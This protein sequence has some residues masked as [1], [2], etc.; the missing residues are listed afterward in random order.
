[1][2]IAHVKRKSVNVMENATNVENIMPSKNVRDLLLVKKK[3]GDEISCLA[4]KFQF[5]AQDKLP[6]ASLLPFKLY[7]TER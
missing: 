4:D 6:Y 5:A 7:P 2:R 3:L 1:M